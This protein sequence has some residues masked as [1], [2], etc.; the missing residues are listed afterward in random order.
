MGQ[1]EARRRNVQLLER[2]SIVFNFY[3]VVAYLIFQ[4]ICDLFLS[5]LWVNNDHVTR[6]PFAVSG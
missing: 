6:H 4:T 2:V 1:S 5:S 3:L